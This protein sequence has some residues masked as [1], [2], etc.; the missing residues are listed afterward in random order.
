LESLIIRTAVGYDAGTLHKVGYTQAKAALFAGRI[1]ETRQFGRENNTH[2]LTA[3][4]CSVGTNW[5]HCKFMR[6]AHRRRTSL[7]RRRSQR[8]MPGSKPETTKLILT[9][10]I[11]DA[12]TL[13]QIQ[14]IT[15]DY[16]ILALY[17]TNG[18]T[19][20]HR[21]AITEL[22]DLRKLFYFR[23]G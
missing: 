15:K 7:F 4:L 20:E 8:I 6:Q 22:E 3:A 5:Q 19:E 2:D 11:I 23:W 17:G 12:A 16:S 18:F 10:A 14:K 13:Q 9:E 1:T 21:T